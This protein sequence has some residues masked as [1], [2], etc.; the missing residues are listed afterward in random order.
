MYA[1]I[2]SIIMDDNMYPEYQKIQ[3]KIVVR[4]WA[5][6]LD[7][8]AS[9][10]NSPTEAAQVWFCCLSFLLI[11]PMVPCLWFLIVITYSLEIYLGKFYEACVKSGFLQGKC[12]FPSD[13]CQEALPICGYVKI[14]PHTGV[15][16][17]TQIIWLWTL[18]S[19]DISHCLWIIK[20]NISPT[21]Q[22]VLASLFVK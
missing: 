10:T 14:I 11:F 15:F 3:S 5:L 12:S 8:P 16:L 6:K 4:S 2:Y 13:W 20:D 17:I 18:N 22:V 1:Y 7:C 9:N 21:A 19:G